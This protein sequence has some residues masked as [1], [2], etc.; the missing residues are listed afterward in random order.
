LLSAARK[1]YDCE[2]WKQFIVRHAAN[3]PEYFSDS[4]C[5][6]WQNENF[7]IVMTEKKEQLIQ[8]VQIAQLEDEL[9][10]LPFAV[11]GLICFTIAVVLGTGS[12]FVFGSRSRP[13]VQTSADTSFPGLTGKPETAAVKPAEIP[14]LSPGGETNSVEPAN[15]EKTLPEG[16]VAVAGGEIAIGGGETKLPLER[17]IVKGFTIA[18]TEV[19]NSQYAEFVRETA[20]PAPADWKAGEF[21]KGTEN[22]PVTNVSFQD[23]N[24]FCKW[25]EK[26]IG[27][28]V[29]LPTEAE[30]ELAARGNGGNKY[31]WGSEWNKQAVISKENG[32][33]ISAVK[34]FS[35]NR[36]PFGAYDMAGN[37]WEWTQDKV[38]RN[39]AVTDEEVKEAL[40]TGQVLRIVK[41]GSS[42][43]P[44]AQISAQA[45]YE[46]PEN[47]KVP[48]VGFRYVVER[49]QN[50]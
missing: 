44:A 38:G 30:W 6:N 19:T 4:F 1:Y 23:A 36:S 29:R 3:K 21:P 37:V 32:G 46:I 47:T 17:V 24:A 43:I 18:E 50:P 35:L 7:K 14:A 13:N 42:L 16:V 39:E 33:K 12:W 49:K 15:T 40:E 20:H 31:P 11:A 34:S 41:G 5:G 2:D 48:S 26:K 27:L 10:L 45:R 9:R 25:L 28:P 22:F 8:T